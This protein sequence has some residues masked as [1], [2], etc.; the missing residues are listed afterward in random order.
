MIPVDCL[1][2]KDFLKDSIG[3]NPGHNSKGFEYERSS[4]YHTGHSKS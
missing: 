4:L 3:K 1:T 2:G